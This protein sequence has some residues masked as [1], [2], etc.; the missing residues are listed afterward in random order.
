MKTSFGKAHASVRAGRG[1][2][3]HDWAAETGRN[4][5]SLYFIE[6]GR[7]AIDADV[8]NALV[9]PC[10]L[11]T[12]ERCRLAQGWADAGIEGSPVRYELRPVTDAGHRV[13]AY[14]SAFLVDLDDADLDRIHA[15]VKDR[16][17]GVLA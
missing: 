4:K 11:T 5:R 14:L 15:I 10:V 3:A 8:V 9:E 16:I 7:T 17:C 2:R 13:A 12:E 1:M 6:S